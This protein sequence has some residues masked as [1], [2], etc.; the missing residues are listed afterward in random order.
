MIGGDRLEQVMVLVR[1]DIHQEVSFALRSNINN[2]L[3]GLRG[4]FTIDP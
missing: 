2:L 3:N 1:V 4:N